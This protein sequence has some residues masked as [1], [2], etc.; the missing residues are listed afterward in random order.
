MLLCS[1]EIL[2]LTIANV[3]IWVD[4]KS[5]R[6]WNHLI[7]AHFL[8][9]GATW[10]K[11]FLWRPPCEVAKKTRQP[12]RLLFSGRWDAPVFPLFCALKVW[13]FDIIMVCPEATL[14]RWAGQPTT[15]T[16]LPSLAAGEKKLN[17]RPNIPP[18]LPVVGGSKNLKLKKYWKTLSFP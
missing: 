10:D 15:T 9:Y 12:G 17:G 14:E 1:S 3:L 4:I 2:G 6:G 8:P 7:R 11:C 13:L 5:A 16:T 18:T